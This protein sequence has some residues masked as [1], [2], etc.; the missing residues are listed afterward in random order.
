MP[1]SVDFVAN[2]VTTTYGDPTDAY[3]NTNTWAAY[4]SKYASTKLWW[5]ID[6]L[7]P[8]T[9]TGYKLGTGSGSNYRSCEVTVSYSDDNVTYTNLQTFTLE[10]SGSQQTFTISS[11]SGYH[12]YYK[13]TF[14]RY[15]QTYDTG[16]AVTTNFVPNGYYKDITNIGDLRKFGYTGDIRTL[17]I[18]KKG[19]Y[20]LEVWGGHGGRG[21]SSNTS[22]GG[23]GGY[24][25][26]YIELNVGDTLYIVSGGG[27]NN[28]Y[29]GGGLSTNGTAYSGHGGG[30]THI[31][32]V[33]GTL[34]D[35]GS[36]NLDKIYI[37]AGGGGGGGEKASKEG[38]T[39]GGVTGGNGSGTY[40]GGGG[41]QTT[42]GANPYFSS[43]TH[44]THGQFGVGGNAEQN[45]SSGANY[46]GGGGGGLY[47]GAGGCW[48]G[49]TYQGG[50]GGGS[51]YIGGVPEITYKGTTYTPVTTNGVNTGSNGYAII[52]LIDIA[53]N[54]RFKIN[55][56]WK[57]ATLYKKINGVW[58]T[59]QL[60]IK[61]NGT[62]ISGI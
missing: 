37:I 22:V 24:S 50:G 59:G 21:S 5:Y 39:G 1:N 42:G 8:V 4:Q 47:G 14:N 40:Y 18:P 27:N 45:P 54:C 44:Y 12:K 17:E 28:R 51:G 30:A 7:M 31:A 16:R 53:G 55:G 58:V 10:A 34:V 56:A 32:N 15:N 35:I 9:L 38:G 29:N 6:F 3:G 2:D 26:G 48:S 43:A 62:W 36:S 49:A 60:R 61:S 57:Y 23:N 19:L 41:T 25:K 11:D 33:T 52:T 13:W 20:Q 46:G